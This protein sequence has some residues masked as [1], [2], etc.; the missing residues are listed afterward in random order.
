MFTPSDAQGL[1]EIRD[2]GASTRGILLRGASIVSMDPGIGDLPTGDL[3]VS[4]STIA[5]IGPDLSGAAGPDTVVIDASG[6]IL[7]PG[8]QD[9]HRHCWQTQFRRWLPDADLAYY[10]ELMH[11]GIAPAYTPHDVYAGTRLAAAGALDAGVTTV[12]DFF[13][14]P[15]TPAH[16]DAA[17]QAWRDSG[18]RAVIANCPTLAGERDGRWLADLTRLRAKE[19]SSDDALVTLRMGVGAK[20]APMVTGELALSADSLESARDLG[21]GVTVD[22]VF[23]PLA[24]EHI[25]EIAA[26]GLLGPDVTWIHCTSLDGEAWRV[27]A[28]A[29]CP[30]V[31]APT[32]DSLLGCE[33][34]VAP[35]LEALEHGVAPALSVD[36]ECSLPSDMFSQMQ[37]VLNAQRMLSQRDRYAGDE[38]APPMLTA[39]EVLGYATVAGAKANGVAAR[40]GSLTPGKQADLLIVDAM[41]VNNMP[42]NDAVGTLVLGADPRNITGVLV[43][44]EPRKWAGRLLDVDPR[45]LAASVMESRDAV[46][47]RSGC[48][49]PIAAAGR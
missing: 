40:T 8:F 49:V 2:R 17:V 31:I 7:A 13:H 5:Q 35:V 48:E 32:S 15:K 38:G 29:G 41:A 47:E 45:E 24:S 21:V 3:L 20:I 46:L 43:A 4:G 44:G 28:D 18:A 25:A 14:N 37:A 42:L 6:H 30:V 10:L 11:F 16:S 1:R 19:L 26:T 27:L 33:A 12:L 9:A 39:R 23:G 22:A 34:G 36:V